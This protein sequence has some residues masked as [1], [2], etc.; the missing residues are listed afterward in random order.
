MSVSWTAGTSSSLNGGG[1]E[2]PVTLILAGPPDSV[3]V[4]QS[5]FGSDPRFRVLM[6]STS[7]DDLRSKLSANPEAI[8]VD[9]LMFSNAAHFAQV[10]TSYQGACYL[11]LVEPNIPQAEID[12]VQ[13][14]PC[15]REILREVPNVTELAGRVYAAVMADRKART[16][17]GTTFGALKLSGTATIGFRAV[18]VW[19]AQGGCGK[20]TLAMALA[21]EAANRNLPTLLVGLGAPDPVPLILR[22]RAEPNIMDWRANN[23]SLKPHLQKYEAGR[24]DVLAG[25]PDPMALSG[26]L[27]DAFH[28]EKGIA[29]L[30]SLAALAGYSVVLLDVSAQELAPAAL[31]AANT[32][33]MPV[34]PDITGLLA[35]EVT[36]GMIF[37]KLAGQHRIPPEG[38]HLVL[39]RVRESS[40]PAAEFARYGGA[41]SA[42]FPPVVA[43]VVDDPEI[44]AAVNQ[45]GV[46]YFRSKA[47]SSVAQNLGNLLFASALAARPETGKAAR[48]LN[49]GPIRI[50]M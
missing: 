35:A 34:R 4:M 43:T 17:L 38:V 30:V 36:T 47:L 27:E 28:P 49:L 13:A 6:S 41:V 20:T 22:L 24:L 8:V 39:N 14:V 5:W 9:G 21:L 46:P 11:F 45:N 42:H 25:F 32:L 40:I 50:K 18:A 33:V 2:Q 16:G 48:V 44:E 26:Y 15:V 29:A 23:T 19:S 1:G 31:S 10:M 12:A 3:R 37:E 7:P